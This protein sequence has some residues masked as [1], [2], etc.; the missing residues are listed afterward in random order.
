MN[1]ALHGETKRTV[2]EADSDAVKSTIGNSLEMQRWMGWIVLDLREISI[3]YG[4][5][6]DGQ[7]VEALPKP[8]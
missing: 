5:N 4:L 8:L 3:R 2:I 6:F 1:A 7:C